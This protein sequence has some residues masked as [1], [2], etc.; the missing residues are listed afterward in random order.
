MT[1]FSA[2]VQQEGDI[3][4]EMERRREGREAVLRQR[5]ERRKQGGLV[6]KIGLG[7]ADKARVLPQ[8][9]TPP[10]PHES[11]QPPSRTPHHSS[12][13]SLPARRGK[14]HA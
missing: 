8:V 2:I 14:A 3:E 5:R 13:T 9:R 10:P 11:S 7:K 12:R 1:L 4:R 6:A